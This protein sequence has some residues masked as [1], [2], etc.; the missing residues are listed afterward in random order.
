M[1]RYVTTTYRL[2]DLTCNESI[3]SLLSCICLVWMFVEFQC[4]VDGLGM[5]FVGGIICPQA[6]QTCCDNTGKSFISESMLLT[7]GNFSDFNP[8]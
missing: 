7:V 4:L 2:H 3:M 8:S 1:E 6:S 5:S